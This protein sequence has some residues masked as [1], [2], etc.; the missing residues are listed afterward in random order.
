MILMVQMQICKAFM[1]DTEK[2]GVAGQDLVGIAQ[3][4]DRN[5]RNDMKKEAKP[6]PNKL[7]YKD[8]PYSMSLIAFC[9]KS[10]DCDLKLHTQE[11]SAV[12]TLI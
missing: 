4:K 3:S 11:L 10:N 9:K 8:F 6:P 5:G 2:A 12:A 7:F 1:A